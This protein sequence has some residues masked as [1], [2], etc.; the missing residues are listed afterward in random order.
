VSGTA[1][2]GTSPGASGK[3]RTFPRSVRLL[4]HSDFQRV[5]QQGRRH[6]AAHLTVFYLPRREGGGLRLGFTVGRVLGGAV[7]RN[8][9]KRRLREAVR[10]HWPG[11][12]VPMDVVMNPKKSMLGIEFSELGKEVAQAFKVIQRFSEEKAL[13]AK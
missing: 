6:F 2:N 11:V 9:M 10:L 8:R 7:D 3:R 12:A 5:Y 1:A 4:R 13:E